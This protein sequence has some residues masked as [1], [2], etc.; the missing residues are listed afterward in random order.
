M[1][2]NMTAY[3][4][5]HKRFGIILAGIIVLNIIYGFDPRFT[6]INILWILISIIK[7]K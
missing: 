5:R 2:E 1:K 4:A 6:V 3:L 7:I